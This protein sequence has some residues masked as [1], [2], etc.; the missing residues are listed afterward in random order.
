MKADCKGSVNVKQTNQACIPSSESVATHED[1]SIIVIL[2]LSTV[3]KIF[4]VY[5]SV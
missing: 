2:I 3:S 4:T 1:N 5:V